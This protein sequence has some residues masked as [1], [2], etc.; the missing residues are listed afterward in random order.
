MYLLLNESGNQNTVGDY[1]DSV[2]MAATSASLS[3]VTNAVTQTATEEV[4]QSTETDSL[5]NMVK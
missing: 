5:L 2:E 3:E 1:T 4:Q